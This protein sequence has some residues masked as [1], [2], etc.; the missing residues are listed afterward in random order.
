MSS[1]HFWVGL[2]VAHGG[3]VCGLFEDVND[4]SNEQSWQVLVLLM[5]ASFADFEDVK[6]MSNEQS[7]VGLGVACGGTVRGCL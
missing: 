1:E 4:M 5:V 7:W 2:G 6:D 3:S